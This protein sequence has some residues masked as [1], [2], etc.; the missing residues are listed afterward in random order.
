MSLFS[1]VKESLSIAHKKVASITGFIKNKLGLSEI[2]LNP[3]KST[4]KKNPK[5]CIIY[6]VSPREHMHS[7]GFM[8]FEKEISK[9]D[10]FIESLKTAVKYLPNYP[11]YIFHEDYTNAD[12]NKVKK[13]AKDRKLIF[14]KVNFD[15]YKGKTNLN[16]WM[17]KQKGFIE[18]RPAGYRMM[19]R[20]FCGVMQNSKELSKFVYHIRMDHDF[21][22]RTS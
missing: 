19:C 4:S 16:D 3:A 6:L 8:G 7:K 21:L 12:K 18:G 1:K 22:H 2:S 9:M 5:L 11:I 20:F 14:V 10:I 17:K 15:L 13:V